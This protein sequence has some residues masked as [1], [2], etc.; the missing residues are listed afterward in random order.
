MQ[1]VKLLAPVLV[2]LVKVKESQVGL[3]ARDLKGCLQVGVCPRRVL[4]HNNKVWHVHTN[5]RIPPSI[6][7]E[8]NCLLCL[9]SIV[10][11]LP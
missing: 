4:H 1:R 6:T 7:G 9:P 2:V 8:T 3:L 10:R 5:Y 11:F